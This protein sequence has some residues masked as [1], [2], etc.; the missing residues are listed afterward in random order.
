MQRFRYSGQNRSIGRTVTL[1]GRKQAHPTKP[2]MLNIKQ[3]LIAIDQFANTLLG[4]WAD[5]TFSAR[6]YRKDWTV[7]VTIIDTVFFLQTEHCKESWKW[8]LERK[9][10]PIEYRGR[11]IEN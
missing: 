4:G 5:E 11:E 8:E 6:C 9:D 2:S 7:L 3:I 10:L 1:T